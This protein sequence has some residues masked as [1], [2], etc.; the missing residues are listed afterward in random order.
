MRQNKSNKGETRLVYWSGFFLSIF[1]V[2]VFMVGYWRFKNQWLLSSIMFY[3]SLLSL[4]ILAVLSL[5]G[6][7][8]WI[9]VYKPWKYGLKRSIW[10]SKVIEEIYVQLTD[11]Q[12]GVVRRGLLKLPRVA[13]VFS[14]NGLVVKIR[15]SIK[16]TAKFE[17]FDISSA[18]NGYVVE[19]RYFSDDMRW[20]VFE[21]FD[22]SSDFGFS[23]NNFEAFCKEAQLVGEYN[24]LIDKRLV[25]RLHHSL[26]VG[27]TGSGKTYALYNIV[28]QGLVKG[29]NISIIDPK[30]SSM[31]N[32]G[33]LIGSS[34]TNKQEIV[35]LIDKFYSDM[36]KRK[37]ELKE[38]LKSG[39][40]K[41]YS[42]FGLKPH[43][44][45]F[46]EYASFESQLKAE[47]KNIRDKT[48]GQLESIILEGRQIGFFV[49]LAMQK[50][51][52][53][54]VNT[55]IR[56]NLVFKCVLGDS[57]RQTYVTAFGSSD[58]PQ[59]KM[60][61]GKGFYTLSGKTHRPKIL[62][63]PQLNFDIYDAFKRSTR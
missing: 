40:E 17:N 29:W 26:I 50:S 25:Y 31:A 27:Q 22:S 5:F 33:E 18:L 12:V 53:S 39:L 36:A 9:I 28:L 57:E 55:L 24:V 58:I 62:I 23:F 51:D 60:I 15:N 4:A 45:I 44:L 2:V 14:K 46:D 48:Q 32:I 52:A 56:D 10:L 37:L 34:A 47:K 1:F 41:D 16:Y 42:D 11:A 30:N 54:V 8:K 3:L 7:V 20:V 35:L 61:V 13:F 43:V 63:M 19:E 38:Q 59:Q 6:S 21:C 49:V